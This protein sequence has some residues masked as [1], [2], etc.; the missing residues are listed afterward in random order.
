MADKLYKDSPPS[1]EPQE[2]PSRG[3]L[4]LMV[5]VAIVLTLVVLA[6]ALSPGTSMVTLPQ[7]A[8]PLTAVPLAVLLLLVYPLWPGTLLGRGDPIN[9][10]WPWLALR[11]AEVTLLLAV[12]LPALLVA[13]ILS[14]APLWRVAE[15]L[16]GL[17]GIASVAIAYRFVHQA[18]SAGLRALA[19]PDVM[20]FLFGPLV[21][22]YLVLESGGR[23]ISW[24]WLISPLALARA[25]AIDGMAIGGA[26]FF[27][28]LIGYTAVSAGG[29][30][31]V[32]RLSRRD[33]RQHIP[34][35]SPL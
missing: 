12:S 20:M 23:S 18:G 29:L 15:L 4:S 5:A 31:L 7:D 33:L 9:R 6:A 30:L 13:T 3:L 27:V 14:G 22:G 34:H 10:L 1:D 21:V 19:V 25:L 17:I 28:G 26:A 24:G 8:L 32:H 11:V 2:L 35:E 16:I